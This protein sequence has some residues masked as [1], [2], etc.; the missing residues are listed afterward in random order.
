MPRPD[1][2]QL[3]AV[4]DYATLFRWNLSFLQFPAAIAFNSDVDLN[5]RCSSVE[6]PSR[7]NQTIITNVRGHQ[8]RDS[9]IVNF[10]DSITLEFTET[11]DNTIHDFLNQWN[12][13]TWSTRTGITASK[14]DLEARI[15]IE[16]LNNQD[17]PIWEYIL[18]GCFIQAFE[19][20]TLDGESSEKILPNITLSYDFFE[21]NRI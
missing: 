13:A 12:E 16:R 15:R 20:G 11:V 14:A 6:L 7:D 4:G 5:L 10:S 21:M 19:L 17:E 18:V 8:R 2:S 3:R 1:L 9:G